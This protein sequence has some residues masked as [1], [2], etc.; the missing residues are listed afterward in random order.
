MSATNE[1]D[2]AHRR[3][4]WETDADFRKDRAAYMRDWNKRNAESVSKTNKAKYERRRV[5][6]SLQDRA[7]Y[8]ADPEKFRLQER[9]ARARQN[10]IV[11]MVR[12]AL[13][14]ERRKKVESA[15]ENGVRRVHRPAKSIVDALV[16]EL[17]PPPTHCPVFL[18]MEL[19]YDGRA[20]TSNT[21]TIDRVD[22]SKG[23]VLGNIAILSSLANTLKSSGSAEDHEKIATWMRLKTGV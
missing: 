7:D 21:A 3:A 10:P 9:E 19:E 15:Y 14:R 4:R 13:C 5:Q 1:K 11:R 18:D 12:K 6:I 17:T 16:A 22:N 23:Y 2:L 20:L 8:A